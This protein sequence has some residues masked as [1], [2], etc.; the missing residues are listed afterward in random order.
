[1][2]SITIRNLDDALKAKLR[3]RAARLGH[4]M[5]E[6]VR[7]ILK[8]VLDAEDSSRSLGESIH[9]RFASLGGFDLPK[10]AREPIRDRPL[11]EDV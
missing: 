9:Q 1:M 8:N 11:F 2:A 5:E 10:L 6:E 3:V 7:L 4:S